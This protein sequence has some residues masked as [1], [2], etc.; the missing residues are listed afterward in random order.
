MLVREAGPPQSHTPI[1]TFVLVD[2]T[3]STTC[4]GPFNN[5]SAFEKSARFLERK[6]M[7]VF[8][9]HKKKETGGRF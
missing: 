9:R 6:T 5:Y 8:R 2:R 4:L 3:T 1:I 7:S